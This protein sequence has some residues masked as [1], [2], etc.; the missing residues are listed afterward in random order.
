MT[1][2]REW[3]YEYQK[4]DGGNVYLGDDAICNI[5]GRSKVLLKFPDGK[6]KTLSDVV[7]MA[8]LSKNLIS[9]S[10]LAKIGVKTFFGGDS[11]RMVKAVKSCGKA[12]KV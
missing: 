3:F 2:L 7:H 9:V 11:C 4:I 5:E 12:L 8:E 10:S 1:P 6:K